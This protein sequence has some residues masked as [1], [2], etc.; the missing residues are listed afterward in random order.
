[1]LATPPL[2]TYVPRA[3]EI[4]NQR[5]L[6]LF[7]QS[8]EPDR[9]RNAVSVVAGAAAL[10]W[11]VVLVLLGDALKRHVEDRLD[12]EDAGG[13]DPSRPSALLRSAV[14][15]GK[16]TI[17]ACSADARLA[18]VKESRLKARVDQVVG[19]TTILRRIQ[20][21]GTKLWI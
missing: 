15:F 4:L 10:N 17:L 3:P 9:I 11:E 2:E 13:D 1:L 7:L 12:P 6:A 18:G 14:D 8:G 19:M 16:V 21:A 5:R 20:N